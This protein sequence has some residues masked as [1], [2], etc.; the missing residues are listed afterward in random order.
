MGL[1]LKMKVKIEVDKGQTKEEAE[2][3]LYKALDS[4]RTGAIHNQEFQDPVMN[5]LFHKLKDV[6]GSIHDDML[7]AIFEELDK[8]HD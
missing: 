5:E 3:V 7:Q 8:E 2:E 4:Q 1:G 6:Y